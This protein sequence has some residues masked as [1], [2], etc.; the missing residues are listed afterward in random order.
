MTG[1]RASRQKGERREREIVQMH[2]DIGGEAARVPL[3]GA[4]GGKFSGDI[5]L[6]PFGIEDMTLVAECKSRSNGQ[7]F[8]QLERWLGDN[9]L[10][11]LVKDR[12]EPTVVLPW[13]TWEL[14]LTRIRARYGPPAHD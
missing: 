3:S 4:A 10:L 12:S 8:V 1:G 14:L 2:R 6:T 11:F 7:G 13:R 9:D 5:D